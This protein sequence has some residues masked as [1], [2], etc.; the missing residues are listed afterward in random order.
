MTDKDAATLPGDHESIAHRM[1]WRYKKSSD[2]A[3]S[4]TYT[5]NEATLRAFVEAIAEQWS[6]AESR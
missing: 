5:F 4:D 6:A 2:P 3:H 1:C